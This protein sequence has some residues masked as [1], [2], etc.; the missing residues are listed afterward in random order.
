MNLMFHWSFSKINHVLQKD[1]SSIVIW[2]SF[3]TLN[4][5]SEEVLC[6]VTPKAMDLAA[7]SVAAYNEVAKN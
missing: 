4:I 1:K 3:M 2:T 7:V 6:I 5:T